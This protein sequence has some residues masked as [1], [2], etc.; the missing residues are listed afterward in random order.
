MQTV[1]VVIGLGEGESA[2]KPSNRCGRYY[3]IGRR[4]VLHELAVNERRGPQ[5]SNRGKESEGKKNE[6]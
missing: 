1:G 6:D 3:R 4:W 5:M 2:I